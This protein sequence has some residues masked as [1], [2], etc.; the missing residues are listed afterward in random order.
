LGTRAIALIIRPRSD[1]PELFADGKRTLNVS[2]YMFGPRMAA[3]VAFSDLSGRRD[4][5]LEEGLHE[6]VT[7]VP[8]RR[9]HVAVGSS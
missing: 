2:S 1:V 7:E 9:T 3:P 6:S 4:F 8:D 5:S